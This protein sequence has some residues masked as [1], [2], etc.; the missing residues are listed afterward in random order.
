MNFKDHLKFRSTLLAALCAAA[1]TAMAM[2]TGT[3][4]SGS[5]TK[6]LM[7]GTIY[8]VSGNVSVSVGDGKN[9]L[10]AKHV[11]GAGGNNYCGGRGERGRE[12]CGGQR[13]R[14]EE[15]QR[16]GGEERQRGSRRRSRP[17][18]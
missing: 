2:E 6:E 13:S 10:E 11:G 15:G 4:T 8:T 9:A 1:P 14:G 17:H 3:I 12:R 18:F 7:G 5:D 16:C